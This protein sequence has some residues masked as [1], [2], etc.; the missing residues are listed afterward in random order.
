[1]HCLYT[2]ATVM[3][4]FRCDMLILLVPLTLQMLISGEIKFWRALF[5]GIVCC[6][7]VLLLTVVIDSYYWKLYY[8]PG[9]VSGLG[10]TEGVDGTLGESNMNLFVSMMK[11]AML[12]ISSFVSSLA[13]VT[14]RL[15]S[16]LLDAQS[17]SSQPQSWGLILTRLWHSLQTI[18]SDSDSGVLFL[19]PE[20]VVLFFNTVENKSSQ[21]GVMS[22]H[23][24]FSNALPKV[25]VYMCV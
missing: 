20:G 7:C 5:N 15:S 23:W 22:T 12:V 13:H 1:M 14:D 21:W 18:V 2:I 24:Y 4:I 11:P 19:W 10:E 6:M 9:I 16:I 8:H 25:V 3:I 17:Q